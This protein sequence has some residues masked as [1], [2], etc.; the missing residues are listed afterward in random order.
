MFGRVTYQK[1]CQPLAP[2]AHRRF[3]VAAALLG[4]QRNEL[5]G[6]ER[7]GDEDRR[8]DDSGHGEDDVHVPGR[9]PFPEPALRSEQENVDQPGNDR[10]DREGQVDEGDQ[11]RFAGEVELGHR[12]GG[13]EPEGDVHRNRDRGDQE[14]QLDRGD[15]VGLGDAVQIDPHSALQRLDED[16]DQGKQQEQGEKGH[17]RGEQQDPAEPAVG[18][19]ADGH[20]SPCSGFAPRPG[21]G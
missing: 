11:D 13:G 5:S 3:L 4:H 15:R 12:P 17:R 9:E 6:D 19:G 14:G 8:Q 10:R 2:E 18:G 7:E 16:R 21:A 20:F 1:A